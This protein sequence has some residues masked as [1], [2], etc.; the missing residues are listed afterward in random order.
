MTFIRTHDSVV[1]SMQNTSLDPSTMTQR[2]NWISNISYSRFSAKLASPT[3]VLNGMAHH[4]IDASTHDH[5]D[6]HLINTSKCICDPLPPHTPPHRRV[7]I[8]RSRRSHH[9]RVKTHPRPPST[10]YTT[11]STCQHPS[12]STSNTRD[13]EGQLGA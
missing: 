11:T 7:N 9:P 10:T 3:S 1:F 6:H 13:D 2:Y 5:H 4:H 8:R 12:T